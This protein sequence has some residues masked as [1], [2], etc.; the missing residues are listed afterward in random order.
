MSDVAAWPITFYDILFNT[1]YYQMYIKVFN[2]TL[3][4][5]SALLLKYHLRIKTW[6]MK[7]ANI[8]LDF[9]AWTAFMLIFGAW[10]PLYM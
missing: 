4:V 6:H 1:Y 10:H 9:I 2:V 5:I 8:I 3:F 7:T